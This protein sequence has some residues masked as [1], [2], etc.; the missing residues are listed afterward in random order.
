MKTETPLTQGIALSAEQ[1]AL[2]KLFLQ[3]DGF[4]S[5]GDNVPSDLVRHNEE[6]RYLPFP[7]TD[8]QLAYMVGRENSQ[9]DLSDVPSRLYMEFDTEDLDPLRYQKAWQ[10]LIARHDMLRCV[11]TAQGKQRILQEVPAFTPRYL[12]L[13]NFSEEK[14][15]QALLALREELSREIRPIDVWPLFS[16][17]V[18]RLDAKNYRI[19]LSF[20]GLIGDML[21]LSIITDELRQLY[22][23]KE[24][25]LP[26]LQ[27]TFRDYVLSL[28]RQKA[29]PSYRLAREYWIK[30]LP[31][32]PTAPQLPLAREAKRGG[33]PA[34]RRFDWHF[35]QK[36]WEKVQHQGERMGLSPTSI[37][38]AAFAEVLALWNR[39]Q[40]F[41]LN[42]TLFNRL[43]VHPQI[44]QIIGDFTDIL[45]LAIRRQAGAGFGQR[46]LALRDQLW[47]DL[48][49]RQFSGLEVMRELNRHRPAEQQQYMPVVFTSA[50][51]MGD[52][53]EKMTRT[54]LNGKPLT[55]TYSISQTPQLLI[56][57][58]VYEE[59]G[60][61]GVRWDVRTE[62]FPPGFIEALFAS[63]C[64][65]IRRLAEDESAWEEESP[66]RLPAMQEQ[67]RS[68]FNNTKTKADEGQM[69]DELLHLLF[70]RRALLQPD[71]LALIARER[72]ISYGELL[73]RAAGV[74][75]ALQGNVSP[76]QLVAVVMEKGWE[77][78]VAVLG[79]L[80]S[81]AAYL[82]LDPTLPPERLRHI[83]ADAAVK[84]VLSQEKYA[85]SLV[86]PEDV[87]CLAVDRLPLGNGKTLAERPPR[88]RPENLA[89]VIYTS[90]S[91]GLPKGVMMEHRAVANTICD[92]NRRLGLGPEDR[93]IALSSLSFDLSVWDIFGT[94]ASGAALV[95]PEAAKEREPGHWLE[96]LERE[97][98]SIWNTVP[99]MM[100]M[101][102]THSKT[103][104]HN[105][106]TRLR[107]V[108]LSG[109]WIPLD[110]PGQLKRQFQA[111]LI[112]LGGAT[113][114]AIWSI[115]HP[116]E[117][118]DPNWKSIPYGRPLDNQCWYV[119]NDE[120][121]ECPDYVVG[122]LYIGG[123]GL[124]RGYWRD[125]EKTQKAFIVHP[126]SGKRLYRTGDL[127]YFHPDGHIV[128]LGRED[129]QLKIRGYRVEPGEIEQTLL[130]HEGIR[131]AV[132]APVGGQTSDQLLAWLT[133]EKENRSLFAVQET[134]PE[135]NHLLWR[136]VTSGEAAGASEDL[137]D[138]KANQPNAELC[139]F[140][141][142]CD[143][144][145]ILSI[146]RLF[147]SF[148]LFLAPGEQHSAHDILAQ[149]R[150]SPRYDKWMFRALRSLAE[151]GILKQEGEHF[152]SIQALA[153]A[154]F[155][156]CIEGLHN[157]LPKDA[158]ISGEHIRL[159]TMIAA[160]LPEILREELHSAEIYASREVQSLY[161][162]M[163]A[164]ANS[165]IRE[166]VRRFL[167]LGGEQ[168]L[169]RFLEAGAG[170]GGCTREILPILPKEGLFYQFT[171]L[172]AYF[173]ENARQRFEDF[174]FLSY[175]IF[176]L[177]QSP[178]CQ[179]LKPHEQDMVI[180][181]SVL[182]DTK[183]IAATLKHILQ[184]LKPGGIFVFTEQTRFF[185]SYDLGMGIQQGFD[186]F[187]DTELR[188][189]HPMISRQQW[190]EQLFA[191]G[192]SRV[193]LLDPQDA[194]YDYLGIDT[195]IAQAPERIEVFDPAIPEA[196]LRARLPAY[197]L[198]SAYLLLDNLPLSATG[199]I[200]RKALLNLPKLAGEALSTQRLAYVEPT[201]DTEQRL[202]AIWSA[203]L[204]VEQVGRDDNYFA[205]G[206]D[207]LLA[208]VLISRI[209]EAFGVDMAVQDVYTL[210]SLREMAAFIE[211]PV[212][213]Q[214][215]ELLVCMQP[216]GQ[217][218]PWF[219]VPGA[220]GGVILSPFHELAALLRPHTQVFTFL[221]AGL[222]GK[223]P[224]LATIE[225]MAELFVE[226]MLRQQPEG[227][228]RLIGYCMGG[229]V[230]LEMARQLQQRGR[231]LDR[232][233]LLD[234]H[235]LPEYIYANDNTLLCMY[236]GMLRIPALLFG[237]D[238]SIMERLRSPQQSL[239]VDC[240]PVIAAQ[241]FAA[242]D[243]QQRLGFVYDQAM[244]KGLLHGYSREGFI[245]LFEIMRLNMRAMHSYAPPTPWQGRIEF[246]LAREEM[247]DKSDAPDSIRYWHRLC[248][249]FEL[250]SIPG[251]HLSIM[252]GEGIREIAEII[253]SSHTASQHITV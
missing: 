175:S 229:F 205:L 1:E 138:S 220:E 58:L 48:D 110:L 163:F 20:E 213:K 60:C 121:N 115:F 179:Q 68:L 203:S 145:Y 4:E 31:K 199:K 209:H 15:E 8:I 127:G 7:L 55:C 91:T 212:K 125:P 157:N 162:R 11:L 13:A 197:M 27:V 63:Y 239:S 98:V 180:A 233:V 153:D 182:H 247:I 166:V 161:V 119:L 147:R 59:G 62:Y 10:K 144:L 34:V 42:L 195:F 65:L 106:P 54:T 45:L 113:E 120:M 188:P 136:A 137:Q 206:G 77:Q 190:H 226:A 79:I 72:S 218:A 241:A 94:L 200:D 44:N 28:E 191:A 128:L 173:L 111:E 22:E 251:N 217:E 250:V 228:L 214:Q 88:Q 38:L 243:L 24:A 169:L 17:V 102:L 109:D 47:D 192:F 124:A 170:H 116:V 6:E 156:A 40:D 114:A 33:A 171:D 248:E 29:L 196:F 90:G 187:E 240:G 78:S 183:D 174:G 245:A 21:S 135:R 50:F 81:G 211:N 141:H 143:Q 49:N 227:P 71:A 198:P 92:I 152:T 142:D 252:Q 85:Q 41:C 134:D 122:Q 76:D 225:E 172:S 70:L 184:L 237:L 168:G 207:S 2:L 219:C 158:L 193:Q 107:G 139:R 208:T 57:H 104:L 74:S 75:A 39:E 12:D 244:A 164:R 123:M 246:F 86:W 236:L 186:R 61:L 253:D 73:D 69:E 235:L 46:A 14:R 66:A 108:L 177:D 232:L 19:H 238:C 151:A 18:S 160:H 30:R 231:V 146:Q 234:A 53:N 16:V 25:A 126:Q 95:L 154:D 224:P 52:L 100:Q 230:A 222:E 80:F 118:V 105:S 51:L 216:L 181:A 89:Y 35:E 23:G 140:W 101:L 130:Q 83:L 189:L 93:V 149:K 103:H 221:P 36:K 165:L 82:P 150:I 43:P 117:A 201:S 194:F 84:Y 26:E 129:N 176:D 87:L 37:L 132:V 202:A 178:L 5:T 96:L 112:S 204:K 131:Q 32:L 159:L 223:T 249:S 215:E 133:P 56:D 148:G 64:D 67:Q 185:P 167:N 9:L 97:G 242:M 155:A 99:A 210:A 3:K